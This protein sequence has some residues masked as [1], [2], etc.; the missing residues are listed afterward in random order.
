VPVD[1]PPKCISFFFLR[2]GGGGGGGPFW[3]ARPPR[4]RAMVVES[5]PAVMPWSRC[6]FAAAGG[7]GD[8]VSG[9][10]GGPEVENLLK[11]SLRSAAGTWFTRDWLS[12]GS[13]CRPSTT[14]LRDERFAVSFAVY[15]R[16]FSTKHP[17][18]LAPGP[19]DPVAR[20]QR[21]KSNTLAGQ[22]QLGPGRRI[23]PRCRRSAAAATSRPVVNA[24]SAILA[25]LGPPCSSLMR[26]QRCRPITTAFL[27]L[28]PEAFRR[29]RRNSI[30]RPECGHFTS[31]P[32]CLQENPGDAR[33]CCVFSDDASVVLRWT[34]NGLAG[35]GAPLLHHSRWPW[36]VD[37]FG[38][39][40]VPIEESG[41]LKKGR[42]GPGQML[43]STLGKRSLCLKNMAGQGRG[44]RPR[45]PYG[46]WLQEQTPQAFQGPA[47]AG[48]P[49]HGRHRSAF[50][51]TRPPSA[52]GEDLDL[53]IEDM[54][55]S[56]Q[57]AHLMH[58]R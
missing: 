7:S 6:C 36:L 31:T 35:L 14:N 38:N 2:G 18:P 41:S 23:P 34:P 20:P 21:L 8:L 12:L 57:G 10:P 43:A 11:L 16:R 45:H 51:S 24:P 54:G 47:L 19:A 39:R 1:P 49:S 3:P 37:G 46:A 29:G 22:S 17:A 9:N 52:H 42:L 44:W 40:V 50:P 5:T 26:A 28:V 30:S 32:P 48:R 55:R 58:G 53:V 4:D 15:H 56:G 25:N 33:R 13:A 27:T